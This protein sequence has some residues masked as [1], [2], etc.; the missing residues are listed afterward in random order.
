MT[1]TFTNAR[2]ADINESISKD[3]DNVWA[4]RNKGIFYLKKKDF[5]QAERLLKQSLDMDS[6][7]DRVHY[8]FGLAYLYN[9]KKEPACIEFKKSEEIGDKMVTADL[10]KQCK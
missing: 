5:S 4:Y 10:I 1:G 3:L 2:Q 9:G 7:V 8:Y 6:F